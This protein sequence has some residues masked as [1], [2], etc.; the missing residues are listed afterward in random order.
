MT[1]VELKARL[2][3]EGLDPR[4]YSIGGSLPNYEGLVLEES[5]GR[6]K[7]EHFERG[8][9]RDLESFTGEEEACQRMYELLT[10]HFR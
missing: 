7:I 1:V 6:W 9:R 3:S 4:V 2:V 10:K 8:I 5:G